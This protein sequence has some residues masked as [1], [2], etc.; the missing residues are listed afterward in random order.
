MTKVFPNDAYSKSQ[1]PRDVM[2]QA[3]FEAKNFKGVRLMRIPTGDF[4]LFKRV[5]AT[6][7]ARELSAVWAWQV[8]RL[9]SRLKNGYMQCGKGPG[10]H[11]NLL[12]SGKWVGG[13]DLVHC[14]NANSWGPVRNEIYGAK[15]P[16]WGD[17]GFG[18][19]TMED[20]FSCAHVHQPYFLMAAS[21]SDTDDILSI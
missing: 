18:L 9:G 20:A 12:H 11:S 14:D 19:C 21:A 13:K 15:G 5:L 8:D 17:G 6:G 16:S 10:N 2:E 4:E 3:D 1:V 7:M